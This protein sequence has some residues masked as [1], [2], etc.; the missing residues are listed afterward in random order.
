MPRGKKEPV[1]QIILY[2]MSVEVEVGRFRRA[3]Q[4]GHPND[5]TRTEDESHNTRNS[6]TLFPPV[7]IHENAFFFVDHAALVNCTAAGRC[8]RRCQL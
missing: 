8:G 2:A 1:E 4:A 5:W 3:G 7:V 6:T